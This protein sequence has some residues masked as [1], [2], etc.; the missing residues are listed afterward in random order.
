MAVQSVEMAEFAK[1]AIHQLWTAISYSTR[2]NM[3]KIIITAQTTPKGVQNPTSAI[4]S[5]VVEKFPH[6]KNKGSDKAIIRN[7][8]QT[9][10]RHNSPYDT[11]YGLVNYIGVKYMKRSTRGRK[12]D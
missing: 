7:N 2:R 5:D 3:G 12:D 11:E 8:P 4:E 9:L 6:E 1:G 10:D